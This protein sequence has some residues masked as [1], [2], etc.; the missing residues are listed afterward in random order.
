MP[1]TLSATLRQV[2]AITPRSRLLTIDLGGQPL[3]FHAGQAVMAG[4][5]GGARRPYSIASSP[6]ASARTGTLEFLVG[7][8]GSPG[9]EHPLASLAPGSAVEIEGPLGS[10]LF[11]PNPHASHLLFIAGGTGIA[12]LRAMLGHARL[13]HPALRASLMYSARRADEFAF[14]PEFEALAATGQLELH[15]TVTRDDG[16]WGG[17]RGRIGRAHFEAVM[18]DPGHTLCF[19]CGPPQM[20]G[21]SVATLTALGVPDAAILREEWGRK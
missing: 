10:F 12:P 7:V 11:P 9:Q 15:R 1:A 14:L 6:E 17:Q 16:D 2:D 13:A 19:V 4:P 5:P 18:H 20:V 21:E 8:G 3:A